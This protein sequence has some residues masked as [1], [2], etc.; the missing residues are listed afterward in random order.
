MKILNSP[1]LLT[2]PFKSKEEI[3]ILKLYQTNDPRK[4]EDL[5]RKLENKEYYA[6]F[7]KMKRHIRLAQAET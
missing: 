2:Y 6:V 5:C 1:H 4:Y 7:L 3:A